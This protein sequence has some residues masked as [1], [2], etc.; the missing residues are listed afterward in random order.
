MAAP[1]W[2]EARAGCEAI[3]DGESRADCLLAAMEVHGRLNPEDCAIIA[4]GRW[5]DECLFLFAERANKAGRLDEAFAA[6]QESGFGRECSFHLIREAARTVKDATPAEAIRAVEPYRGL[7][8]A[9]DAESLFWQAWYREQ[10]AEGLPVDPTS[11][12]DD[13]CRDAA[14]AIVFQ[15]L[16]GLFTANPSGWCSWVP[17]PGEPL[18][19]VAP[20]APPVTGRGQPAWIASPLVE[21][22]VVKWSLRNCARWRDPR[23]RPDA[24]NPFEAFKPERTGG[25]EAVPPG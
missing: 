1:S 12:P 19:G 20:P 11:C 10:A 4:P 13:V 18:A 3:R 25:P 6:C 7:A 8:R 23:P 24:P 5:H 17:A 2:P 15:R 9:P 21:E 14:R 22:W 16:N